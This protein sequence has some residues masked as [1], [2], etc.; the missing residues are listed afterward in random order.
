MQNHH[1]FGVPIVAQRLTNLTSIHEDT[2]LIPGLALWVKDPALLWLWR[3]PVA[4]VLIRPLAWEP[5]CAVGAALKSKKTKQ[6]TNTM[7]SS[8]A[9][10]C[11]WLDGRPAGFG[12]I[13]PIFW[14]S[15]SHTYLTM[16]YNC[17]NNKNDENNKIIT[18]YWIRHHLH[19]LLFNL[20]SYIT[21]MSYI[22]FILK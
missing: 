10:K 3:G 12:F 16:T 6:K 14:V 20:H 5:A 8:E 15:V 1:P 13:N 19:L 7:P 11:G 18:I 2:D 9:K 21:Y 17:N 4:T 22:T